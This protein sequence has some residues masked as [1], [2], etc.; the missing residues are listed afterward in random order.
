ME[1]V[2]NFFKEMNLYDEKLFKTLIKNTKIIHRPYEEIKEYVG[3][4]L[5]ENQIK[6]ILPDIISKMD[7]LIYVHEYTHALFSEDEDELFPNIMEATYINKYFTNEQKEIVVQKAKEIIASSESE[8]HIV[9]NK[10]KLN[11]ITK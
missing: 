8:E 4:F 5:I 10:V 6:I 11:A 2:I 1:Q 9:G 7:E 3:C